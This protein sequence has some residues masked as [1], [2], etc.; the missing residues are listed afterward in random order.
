[1]L[2]YIPQRYRVYMQQEYMF[3]AVNANSEEEKNMKAMEEELKDAKAKIAGLEKANSDNISVPADNP[4]QLH[5]I[6]KA[7]IAGMEDDKSEMAKGMKGME[8][9]EKEVVARVMK[10][11]ENVF[12]QGNGTNRQVAKILGEPATK[13]TEAQAQTAATIA[14]LES[15]YKAPIINKILTAK[16]LSGSTEAEIKDETSRL[17]NLSLIAL[18]SEYNASKVFIEK[19][20]SADTSVPTSPTQEQSTLVGSQES[21]F[22]FNGVQSSNALVGNTVSLD[23]ILGGIN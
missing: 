18:E 6:F 5:S 22:D 9:E 11:M 4:R 1:M 16:T 10:A 2:P 20:L 7:I 17:T 12:D 13:V 8:D 15:K 19:A 21:T 3:K 23:K 14:S